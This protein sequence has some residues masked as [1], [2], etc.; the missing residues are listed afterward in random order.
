MLACTSFE[1]GL[2]SSTACQGCTYHLLQI[3]QV[4]S[5]FSCLGECCNPVCL[6]P[7]KHFLDCFENFP[8][9]LGWADYEW[10]FCISSSSK[11]FTLSTSPLDCNTYVNNTGLFVGWRPWTSEHQSWVEQDTNSFER[12]RTQRCGLSVQEASND[13][14]CPCRGGCAQSS[15]HR[16]VSSCKQLWESN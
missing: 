10:I 6:K 11:S 14:V 7:Q 1:F 16:T 13:V 5:F 2:T 12:I 15:V 4:R 8:S 3:R 9:T